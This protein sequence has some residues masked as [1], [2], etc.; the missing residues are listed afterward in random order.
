MTNIIAIASEKGGVAK[1]TSAIS[2]GGALV[3]MGQDVL[4]IDMDPQAS[5]TLS[6]G[7][8]PHKVRRS[9][10]DVLINSVSPVSVSRET[11][12][13][14]LDLL[15]SN[16]EMELAERFMPIR[17]NYKHILRDT[18]Q[19]THFYDTIIL[20]CPPSLGA[21]THN[22]LVAADMLII[23][24]IPEYLS[25]YSLRNIMRVLRSVRAQDN[26]PLNY[27]ILITMLDQRIASH[28]TLSSQLRA[29]FNNAVFDTVI[30]V[31]TR[32]RD[33]TIAGIPITHY[34]K[35]TRSAEQ[36]RALAQELP[37]YVRSEKV[38][39]AA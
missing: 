38:E 29:T 37:Q 21:V 18:L 10:A 20:D 1:T 17:K 28:I 13:P 30:Q 27:R 26:P 2:L 11:T 32:L 23:P 35:N 19:D 6:L 34:A 8:A 3:E 14:G 15:P 39:Q 25:V 31:D 16:S 22:A 12:I 36:Y 5:L 7:I 4:M 9:I 33:S 24:T